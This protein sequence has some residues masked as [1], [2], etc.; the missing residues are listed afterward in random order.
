MSGPSDQA[1]GVGA[2]TATAGNAGRASVEALGARAEAPARALAHPR[3]VADRAALAAALARRPRRPPFGGASGAAMAARI[4]RRTMPLRFLAR[5]TPLWL[6][7]AAAPALHASVTRG[8]EEIRLA[9]VAT[10]AAAAVSPS[11]LE[12]PAPAAIPNR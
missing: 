2:A 3:P 8:A 12:W 7:V 4:D 6:A 9:G 11:A 5:R 10:A 1:G